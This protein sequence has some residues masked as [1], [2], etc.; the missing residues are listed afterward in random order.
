MKSVN[1]RIAAP[2][3]LRLGRQRAN[4]ASDKPAY[5]RQ[6]DE[7]PRLESTRCYIEQGF[8]CLT[9]DAQHGISSKVLE[10]QRLHEVGACHERRT[11]QSGRRTD[12]S[13][14]QEHTPHDAEVQGSLL[15]QGSGDSVRLP[16]RPPAPLS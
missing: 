5:S 12:H 3:A 15:H 14:M 10:Q 4:D 16:R 9:M 6:K 2:A 1:H 11:A 13:S 7:E 8:G